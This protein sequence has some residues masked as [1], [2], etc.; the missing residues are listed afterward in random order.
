MVLHESA[1]CTIG[2][3]YISLGS[4]ASHSHFEGFCP[5]GAMVCPRLVAHFLIAG[6]RVPPR[7]SS[8]SHAVYTI[9]S[10]GEQGRAL[11]SVEPLFRLVFS[12]LP[13]LSIYDFPLPPHTPHGH[14]CIKFL[15]LLLICALYLF[16]IFTI[17]DG[18][19]VRHPGSRN[20]YCLGRE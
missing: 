17:L 10:A 16:L 6:C 4:F 12:V 11:C 18:C 20:T 13:L 3:A 15:D 2:C 9:S 7:P 19:A 14:H 8:S 1:L 5:S